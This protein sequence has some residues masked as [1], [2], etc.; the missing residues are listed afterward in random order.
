[1]TIDTNP[2]GIDPNVYI[3]RPTSTDFVVL[4][5]V[6]AVVKDETAKQMAT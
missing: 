2:D 6:H 3:R 1:M 4:I 5:R